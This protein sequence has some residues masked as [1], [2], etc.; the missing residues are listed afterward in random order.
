MKKLL[1]VLYYVLYKLY[2][3]DNSRNSAPFFISS[4]WIGTWQFF[5]ILVV[6]SYIE[7]FTGKLIFNPLSNAVIFIGCMF[8]FGL[9]NYLLVSIGN[10]EEN[11]LKIKLSKFKINL[12]SAFFLITMIIGLLLLVFVTQKMRIVFPGQID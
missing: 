3:R 7:I 9:I 12:Y 6:F 2:T 5:W 1:D 4:L 10:R 8:G 11:I